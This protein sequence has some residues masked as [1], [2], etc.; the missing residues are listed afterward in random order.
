MIGYSVTR[1]PIETLRFYFS[2]MNSIKNYI[3][4]AHYLDQTEPLTFNGG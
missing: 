3:K 2:L 1:K 4:L